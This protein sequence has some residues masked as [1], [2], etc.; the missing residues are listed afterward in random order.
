MMAGFSV[1]DP[2]R[3]GG[4]GKPTGPGTGPEATPT[5]EDE[6]V[7]AAGTHA[8]PPLFG[9]K[10]SAKEGTRV[11]DHAPVN[12]KKEQIC[13]PNACWRKCQ[14]PNCTR[15]HESLGKWA[16]LDWSVQLLVVRNHGL[17]SGKRLSE[18]RRGE[19][20]SHRGPCCARVV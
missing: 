8:P 1:T 17:A 3:P 14:S 15:A 9:P 5:P 11:K 20:K 19:G 7:R 6:Q 2:S 18:G 16:T 12:R 13:I 4:K 10:L